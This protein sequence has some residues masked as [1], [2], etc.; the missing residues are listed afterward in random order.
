MGYQPRLSGNCTASSIEPRESKLDSRSADFQQLGAP[1][2]STKT[3]TPV[4][5]N[6]LIRTAHRHA[7]KVPLK[8]AFLPAGRVRQM[9]AAKV[10]PIVVVPIA[11]QNSTR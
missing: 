8:L 10:G 1:R 4:A 11:A 6:P 9:A 7:R 5:T 3:A 2:S